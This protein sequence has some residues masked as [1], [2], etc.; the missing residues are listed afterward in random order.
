MR[1]DVIFIMMIITDD[2]IQWLLADQKVEM[3]KIIK[4]LIVTITKG[5]SRLEGPGQEIGPGSSYSGNSLSKGE[6]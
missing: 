1:S 4:M 3:M 2:L 5:L 6:V